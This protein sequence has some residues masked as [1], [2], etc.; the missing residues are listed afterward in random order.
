MV[1]DLWGR[2][3][4]GA[5][6][7]L[8]IIAGLPRIS[9]ELNVFDRFH[10]Y[11][12]ARTKIDTPILERDLSRSP[13]IAD[14]QVALTVLWDQE[15]AASAFANAIANATAEFLVFTHCDVYFPERWFERLAW[16]LDRLTRMDGRWAV[17][18]FSGMTASG[19]QVGRIWDCSLD[20]WTRGVFGKKL[21]APVPIVSADE[22][23]F[24]V[25]RSAGITFDPKLPEF[26]LYTTD[27]IL[28]AERAGLRC[29]GL[30]MPLIHNAKAQ[31]YVGR[32]YRR[33]YRYMIKKWRERLPVPTTCGPLSPVPFAI[34]RRHLRMRYKAIFRRSTYSTH[35]I[36]DPSVKSRELG[37]DEC[38]LEGMAGR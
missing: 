2:L 27:I 12:C 33:A 34:W 9:G 1:F 20:P 15:S 19:E 36:P 3:H 31:L 4:A 8:S 16:E 10:V 35:R 37:L 5:P 23:A 21:L 14:K 30:D 11:V 38:L 28:T 7:D 13:A 22:M 32:D 18:G 17:A 6:I 29:Y 24:V 26:H 25:R